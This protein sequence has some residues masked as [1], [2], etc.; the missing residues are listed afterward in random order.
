MRSFNLVCDALGAFVRV[1]TLLLATALFAVVISTVVLRGTVG[2][3][4]SWSEEVPRYLLIWVGFMSAA[5]GVD[6]KDHIALELL[7]EH[8][9]GRARLLL[10]SLVDL[11]IIGFGTIML[12]YGLR[13]VQD[14]GADMMESIPYRN[15]WYYV[16]LPLS[17]GLI[18][19][20]AL[21][22]LLN[23]WLAPA[24]RT[25]R[26]DLDAAAVE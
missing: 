2:W 21:R 24:L 4:P 19:L 11:A 3:V 7:Y 16:A 8:L 10:H 23:L 5:M 9:A 17:G 15:Y 25:R 6:L 22:D 14:F 26:I 13:F 12:I 18:I 1:W 20:F